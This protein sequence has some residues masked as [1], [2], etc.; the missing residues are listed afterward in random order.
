MIHGPSRISGHSGTDKK[1][2][3]AFTKWRKWQREDSM[4][5]E[6][7]RETAQRSGRYVSEHKRSASERNWLIILGLPIVLIA[8]IGGAWLLYHA[9]GGVLSSIDQPE[10]LTLPPQNDV[11]RLQAYRS[12]QRTANNN[13]Q[14]GDYEEARDNF[15]LALE[16]AP[17][18]QTARK[19]LVEVVEYICEKDLNY[20]EEALTQRDYLNKTV[21]RKEP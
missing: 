16:M 2:K 15:Y 5:Y 3:K 20:C 18:S 6:G 11:Q 19:G 8:L 12:Y 10:I 9:A 7:G 4:T 21:R 1:H 14:K 17:F 13:L